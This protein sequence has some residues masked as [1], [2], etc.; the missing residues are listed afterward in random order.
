MIVRQNLATVPIRNYTLYLFGCLAL[1]VIVVL[2]A[3]W[4]FIILSHGLLEISRLDSDIGKQQAQLMQLQN[5][6][7]T[8]QGK[9]QRIKTPQFVNEVAFMN[10]IIKRRVFSWTGLFD[11]L[12]RTLPENVKMVSVFPSIQEGNIRINM[13]VAGKNLNDVVKLL[14]VLQNSPI[15][16]D[17]TFRSERQAE[18]GLLHANLSLLYL[19]QKINEKGVSPAPASS[20]AKEEQE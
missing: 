15:F 8:L 18:D 20:V 16:V 14:L 6:A 11:H 5:Q 19:P 7:S 12:E 13:E 17:V 3:S 1:A 4:N 10:Q 9:I 2:V